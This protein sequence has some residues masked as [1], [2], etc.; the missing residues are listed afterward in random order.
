M[1]IDKVF[2]YNNTFLIQDEVLA[3]RLVPFLCYVAMHMHLVTYSDGRHPTLP[4]PILPHPT[5]P[6]PWNNFGKKWDGFHG[7][8]HYVSLLVDKNVGHIDL[9]FHLHT[10]G[11]KVRIYAQYE[12]SK[13]KAVARTTVH[14]SQCRT[15]MMTHDGQ[16]MI[17]RLFGFYTK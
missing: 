15:T 13:V 12:T 8:L 10:K 6:H 17:T 11:T 14:G 3:H 5:L 1:A 16:S 2:I 7:V 4:H 9:I